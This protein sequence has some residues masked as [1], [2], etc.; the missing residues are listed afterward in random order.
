MPWSY[1]KHEED[2]TCGLGARFA[3]VWVSFCSRRSIDSAWLTYLAGIQPSQG[4][5]DEPNSS[6]AILDHRLFLGTQLRGRG[7][8]GCRQVSQSAPERTTAGTQ[9]ADRYLYLYSLITDDST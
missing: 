5:Q 1:P 4:S 3:S 7:R 2:P 8:S 6:A 9:A